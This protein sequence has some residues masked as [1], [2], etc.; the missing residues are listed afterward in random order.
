[1]DCVNELCKFLK[2][3]DLPFGGIPFVGIG[4]FRQVAP[5]VKGAGCGPSRLASVKSSTIWHRFNVLRLHVP[6][7]SARDPVYTQFVDD[8]G[9][10]YLQRRVRIDLL[11]TVQNI[12]EC[13]SFLFPPTVLANPLRALKRAF[14][15]PKNN[16]VDEFNYKV[17]ECVDEVERACLTVCNEYKT[18]PP[19]FFAFQTFFTVR[20]LSKKTLNPQ[21]MN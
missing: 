10:N 14:L 20:T 19:F 7:R 21:N 9:E 15:S 1:M 2:N 3:N 13:V 18:H 12:D 11:D 17:L 16:N 8:I 6:I 4:D 5:V